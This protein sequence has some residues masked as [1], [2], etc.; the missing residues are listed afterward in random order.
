M[1]KSQFFN[2]NLERVSLI[3][4]QIANYLE[5]MTAILT[6]AEIQGEKS[7]GRLSLEGEIEQL[8]ITS[9]NPIKTDLGY[10]YWEI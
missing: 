9:N 1:S 7:S 4:H 5:E 3:R 10:W 6:E 8:Q 2:D